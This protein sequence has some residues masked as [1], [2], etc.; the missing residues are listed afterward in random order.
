MLTA[1]E[2]LPTQDLAAPHRPTRK[3]D[4][5]ASLQGQRNSAPDNPA[6]GFT[7]TLTLHQLPDTAPALGAGSSPYRSKN[8]I[9]SEAVSLD[10]SSTYGIETHSSLYS[11]DQ[12]IVGNHGPV[13][14]PVG[15]SHMEHFTTKVVSTLV[16]NQNSEAGG[17][18]GFPASDTF[19]G[20]PPTNQ[21]AASKRHSRPKPIRERSQLGT[22]LLLPRQ[23]CQPFPHFSRALALSTKTMVIL[24]SNYSTHQ[25]QLRKLRLWSTSHPRIRSRARVIVSAN[26]RIL[27]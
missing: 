17:T 8:T 12:F 19:S 2:S 26:H 14:R 10:G 3:S 6:H 22:L 27:P 24:C 1:L 18:S 25:R 5:S 9:I 16:N 20:H 4:A 13:R 21:L 23:T 7:A 11:N 15:S